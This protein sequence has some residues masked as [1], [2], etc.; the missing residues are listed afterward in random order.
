M[1]RLKKF[2]GCL[3]L[4]RFISMGH[5]QVC[6]EHILK[7]NE[8]LP[9]LVSLLATGIEAQCIRQ[10]AGGE[11]QKQSRGLVVPFQIDTFY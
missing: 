9:R 8:R 6:T 11:R 3:N 5:K 7:M 1:R 10:V 4:E 2:D